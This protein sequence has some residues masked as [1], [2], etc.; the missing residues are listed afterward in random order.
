MVP[1]VECGH[2]ASGETSSSSANTQTEVV[3]QMADHLKDWFSNVLLSVFLFFSFMLSSSFDL[4][5]LIFFGR[6]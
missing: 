6:G 3:A 5:D 4:G 1:F 2:A